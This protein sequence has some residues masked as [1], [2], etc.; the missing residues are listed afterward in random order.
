MAAHADLDVLTDATRSKIV[1]AKAYSA[2]FD[3]VGNI[4][5]NHQPSIKSI[6][7]MKQTP[8]YSLDVDPLSIKPPMSHLFNNTIM[9]LWLNSPIK[10]VIFVG[11]HNIDCYGPIQAARYKHTRTGRFDGVHLNGSSGNKAYTQ[12]VLNILKRANFISKNFDFHQS[13]AQTK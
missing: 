7:F 8:R 12:S 13:C 5:K 1:Q 2:V 4:A 3:E 10:D 6:L 9:N 11:T